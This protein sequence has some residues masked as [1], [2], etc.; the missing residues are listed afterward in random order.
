MACNNC[1]NTCGTT[2]CQC[3]PCYN[4]LVGDCKE[5]CDNTTAQPIDC[6]TQEYCNDG[7]ESFLE[8]KC[9]LFSDGETLEQ[10]WTTLIN[11]LNQLSECICENTGGCPNL[12]T[13][14]GNNTICV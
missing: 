6:L 7:C 3:H 4:T 2:P 1:K 14:T 9:I 11:T 5:P 13:A 10:K 12:G 8:A